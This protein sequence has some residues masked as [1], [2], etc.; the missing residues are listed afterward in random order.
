MWFFP[1]KKEIEKAKLEEDLQVVKVAL[2][3]CIDFRAIG[4]TFNYMGVKMFVTS[5]GTP[6]FSFYGG[7]YM[8]PD[9]H[10]DY[11][12]K[13]GEVKSISFSYDQLVILQEQN[14]PWV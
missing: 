13:Q 3:E 11:V 7:S 9:I 8:I 12:N 5:H 4:E 2:Q 6:S 14:R 10:A 1:K